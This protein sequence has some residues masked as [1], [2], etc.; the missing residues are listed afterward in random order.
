M[1]VRASQHGSVKD[2]RKREIVGI[3]CTAGDEAG[4]FS[5]SDSGSE[6]FGGHFF[7]LKCLNAEFA[8]HAEHAGNVT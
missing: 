2:G 4:I 6:N 5:P 3:G 7:S 8:G 1:G